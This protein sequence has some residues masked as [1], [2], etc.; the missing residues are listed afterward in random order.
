MPGEL[1]EV[2]NVIVVRSHGPR[3]S[4]MSLQPVGDS[5]RACTF[6]FSNR[7]MSVGGCRDL[8]SLCEIGSLPD[9]D[10]VDHEGLMVAAA[11]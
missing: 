8:E 9:L 4:S 7:K 6:L 5:R 2:L 1:D 10:A 3:S 11:L